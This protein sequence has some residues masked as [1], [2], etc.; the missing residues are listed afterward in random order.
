MFGFHKS[1]KME[2]FKRGYEM[3]KVNWS[4]WNKLQRKTESLLGIETTTSRTPGGRSNHSWRARSF[5][6]VHVGS[7]EDACRIWSRSV[8][9]PCS[10]WL[11]VAQ[12]MESRR[13]VFRR[14]RVRDSDFFSLSHA[15]V[16]FGF[17][18][19]KSISETDSG[20]SKPFL[21]QFMSYYIENPNSGF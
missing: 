4:T 1:I 12:W 9:W 14:S 10:L 17:V 19:L 18:P 16:K 11:L 5:N 21:I 8:E 13:P 2:N 3:W 6:W 7:E 15:L 20:A